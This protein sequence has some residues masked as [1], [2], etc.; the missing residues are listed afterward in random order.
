MTHFNKTGCLLPPQKKNSI[1]CLICWEMDDRRNSKGCRLRA[2]QGRANE[3]SCEASGQS[4][5]SALQT[6]WWHLQSGDGLFSLLEIP[7]AWLDVGQPAFVGKVGSPGKVLWNGVLLQESSAGHIHVQGQ[8]AIPSPQTLLVSS[9][10]L[11]T[12]YFQRY[13]RIREQ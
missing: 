7:V 12:S 5:I 1:R 6:M 4:M 8:H 11:H 13:R 9:P 2:L 3:L 10:D